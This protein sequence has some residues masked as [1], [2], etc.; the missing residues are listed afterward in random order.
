MYYHYY[1]NHI[2]IWW[3]DYLL[4]LGYRTK[5]NTGSPMDG[6]YRYGDYGFAVFSKLRNKLEFV[7]EHLLSNTTFI[8]QSDWPISEYR[9]DN[10]IKP[11]YLIEDLLKVTLK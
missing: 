6:L 3:K 4:G 10:F 2:I 9:E 5:Y 11:Y 1:H 8:G 7:I